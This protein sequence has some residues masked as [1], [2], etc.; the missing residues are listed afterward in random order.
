MGLA[1]G[2]GKKYFTPKPKISGK[3][4]FLLV[5]NCFSYYH[6][7]IFSNTSSKFKNIKVYSSN[8]CCRLRMD[9]ILLAYS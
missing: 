2:K 4:R 7:I 9:V 3:V 8:S 6:W 5:Q 1:W